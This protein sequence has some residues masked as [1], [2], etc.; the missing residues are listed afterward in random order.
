MSR[1]TFRNRYYLEELSCDSTVDGEPAVPN[2]KH[3]GESIKSM[4]DFVS[5]WQL[6]NARNKYPKE[7]LGI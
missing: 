6:V 1:L 3:I 4:L 7:Y 2:T 5:C